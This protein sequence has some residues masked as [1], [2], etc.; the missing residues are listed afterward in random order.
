MR[1]PVSLRQR[2]VSGGSDALMATYA[3]GLLPIENKKQA[4]TKPA[5]RNYVA[6]VKCEL[7]RRASILRL[8][9]LTALKYL[10]PGMPKASSSIDEVKMTYRKCGERAMFQHAHGAHSRKTNRSCPDPSTFSTSLPQQEAQG[11]ITYDS[12]PRSNQV[13]DVVY[14]F[15]DEQ[16][17]P[18]DT[19]ARAQNLPQM[20]DSVGRS[21]ERPV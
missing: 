15:Q 13:Y 11:A 8:T 14:G 4:M 16:D 18:P 20:S 21:K 10:I 12:E 1:R 3:L 7:C 5:I 19:V 2:V 17:L 6:S 9:W